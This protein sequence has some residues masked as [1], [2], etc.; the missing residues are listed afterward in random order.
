MARARVLTACAGLVGLVNVVR[1]RIVVLVLVLDVAGNSEVSAIEGATVEHERGLG[2]GRLLKV[3]GSRMR[4]GVKLDGGDLAAE[5]GVA[6]C[7][8]LTVFDY[9]DPRGHT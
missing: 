4:R 5:P 1:V 6:A 7:V 9:G 3:E 2:R 8:S